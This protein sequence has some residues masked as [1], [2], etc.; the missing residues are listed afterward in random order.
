MD[1]GATLEPLAVAWYGV[2]KSGFKIGQTALING[3]GPV[4]HLQHHLRRGQVITTVF[5]IDRIVPP[6]SFTVCFIS[7]F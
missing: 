4:C 7:C 2:K 6:Q 1:V 5:F 3:A